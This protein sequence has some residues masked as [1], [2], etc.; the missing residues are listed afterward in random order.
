MGTADV[1]I[2]EHIGTGDGSIHMGLRREMDDRFD[3]VDAQ[4]F[5]HQRL[6]PDIAVDESKVPALLGTR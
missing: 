6:I 3:I 2:H 5:F 1:D 4:Q